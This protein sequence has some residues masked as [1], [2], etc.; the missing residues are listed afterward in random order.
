M[1]IRYS[2]PPPVIT[3]SERVG[4][5]AYGNSVR[6]AMVCMVVAEG[7]VHEIIRWEWRCENVES[8]AG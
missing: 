4:C 8:T 5:T 2:T 3:L 7:W 1:L 6:L